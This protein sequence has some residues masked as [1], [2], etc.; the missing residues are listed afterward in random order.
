MI[1][2]SQERMV[3]IVPAGALGGGRARSAS[4]GA[5]RCAIDRP[6]HRR[7]RHRRSSRAALDADGRP[8]PGAGS[9]PACR[10][11]P[12]RREAIVFDRAGRARRRAAAA[13]GARAP[14]DGPRTA[15]PERGMDPGAVL[16]RAARHRRTSSSRRWVYEQY[17]RHVQ[18]NTV[19]GPGHGA[20]VLRVKGTTKALVATTDGNAGGRRPG[21]VAG[22]RAVASPR[23][24][25][26]CRSPGA[27]P[28]GVTNCLNYGDPTRPEAFWQL[29]EARPRPRR[30]LPG[31]RP[32]RDRRQR[33]AL[34]RGARRARS[35]RRPRSASSG[36]WTTSRRSSGRRSRP[37]ATRSLLVG[38]TAPGPGRLARTRAWPGPPR[39]TARRPS[40]S[41]AR[42]RLQAFIREAIARGLVGLCPGRLA[43]AAS[44]WPLAEMR[45]LGRPRRA[46]CGCARRG[47]AGRRAVRREPVA[48]SSSTCRPAARRRRSSCWPASTAC[49]SRDARARP[50]ATGCASSW[51]ARAPRARPRSAGAGSPTRSTSPLADLRHAWEHGLPRAL[52]WERAG[53]GAVAAALPGAEAPADV[54][55]RRG[56]L[57]RGRRGR[58][59]SPRSGCSRSSTAARSRPG[60][61]SPTATQLML[62]KDLG[63]DR[64]GPRRAAPAEPPRR[65]RDRPLPLLHDRLDGLGERPADAPPR[66]A[67]GRSRSGTTATS[68]TPASCSAQL[69]GRPRRLPATHG[70]GAPDGAP[71]RRAGRGHGRGARSASCRAVRGAYSP[72]RP[73]RAAR[74]RRPRSARLPAAR[75][76]PARRRARRDEPAGRRATSPAAG[77]SPRRRPASTSWA[78]RVRARRGAGRDRGP[79]GRAGSRVSVR[80]AEA[81]PALCV[82][83]LIYFARPDSYMEGRNL[84]EAR[85]RMGD[86]SSPPSTPVGG[87]PR[88]ARAGHRRAGGGRLRGG[89]GHPVPR[90]HGPQPLRGPDLHPAL[91]RRCA[92]AASPSS[93]TRCAR[94]SGQAPGRRGRLDRARHHDPPDRGAAAPGRRGGGPRPDQRPAHLPPLLLRHRHPDRDR[95]DR[96]DATRW[97]RSASSS[98]PIRSATCRS[99]ASCRRWTCPTSGSASPASTGATR[100]RSRT[101]RPP[102]VR[103]RGRGGRA[104][105]AGRSRATARI[106]AT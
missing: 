21:P 54:R 66:A 4:A 76:G 34:Q 101:T 64:P 20:A 33:L 82:F 55:R 70:H 39:R 8:S 22:R 44:P 74:H 106:D 3:A 67:A 17:D 48:R 102:Q 6:G 28:L 45:D 30:R 9:S 15:C 89:V 14:A 16:A 61:P 1:S 50:A 51:P 80:F 57:R 104:G 79:R 24:P 36:C 43:A 72:G 59:G 97:R 86:G 42:R 62:Y 73:R 56:G 100:S 65:P 32:A 87:G 29:A 99:G 94:S 103:A 52:G 31:A 19:A 95:A 47:L 98:A 84:Y 83:E 25:A 60:S 37:T 91:A 90:G 18:T 27:R 5:S 71:R 35:R 85:R 58:R 105:L 13:P 38:E 23:R 96:G 88:D 40:T 75:P 78:A 46:A 93:S 12:S 10:P 63:H 41:T 2:E 26:T 53:A 81:T 69:R 11:A 92:S 68:S 49:P 77:S 7:R